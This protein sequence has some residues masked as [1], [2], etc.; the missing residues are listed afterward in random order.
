MAITAVLQNLSNSSRISEEFRADNT[1]VTIEFT[2][3]SM[4]TYDSVSTVPQVD[5]A[6]TESTSIRIT[7]PYNIHLNVSIVASLCGQ[8][9]T[10]EYSLYYGKL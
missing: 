2:G 5:V 8:N 10:S 1:I 3:E 7:V 6:V 9:S 4:V